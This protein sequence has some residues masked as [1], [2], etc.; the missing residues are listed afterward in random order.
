MAIAHMLIRKAKNFLYDFSCVCKYSMGHTRARE[1][2]DKILIY[3]D[4]RMGDILMDACAVRCL[5][6]YYLQAGKHIYFV[7]SEATRAALALFMSLKEI[8]YISAKMEN[9]D[10]INIDSI[11]KF[12]KQEYFDKI[13][14]FTQWE[15]LWILNLIACANC[16]ESWEVVSKK[17][18]RRMDLLIYFLKCMHR[19]FTNRII[20]DRETHLTDR[21]KLLLTS[22][23]IKDFKT[24][25]VYL[26]KACDFSMPKPYMTISVDS[27]D[28]KRR[29]QAEKFI[30]LIRLLLN[31]RKEDIYLTGVHVD[32]SDLK[33][34]ENAFQCED[35]V[36]MKVG[37]LQL[38]EWV[39]LIRGSSLLIGVDS[40]AIH[41]AASVGTK[42]ICL[43][44]AW[45]G[46]RVIPYQRDI[47]T[48]RTEPPVCVF[49]SDV[50]PKD[51]PCYGCLGIRD[52]GY[53]N[54]QCATECK[55]RRPCLCLQAIEVDDVWNV[56]RN[57]T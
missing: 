10:A 17:K 20:V 5:V 12:L 13:I 44:G 18:N 43:T 1:E 6:D 52:I 25:I 8:T 42:S 56:A 4:G 3:I 37:Q 15:R 51:L 53:G 16:N 48:D 33:K 29:W 27:N 22:L 21:S 2:S 30:Q 7:G 28:S 54:E 49:R 31:H 45:D 41:V 19:D 23:G 39:E 24:S 14:I 32:S 36:K 34:Y 9:A 57:M 11:E 50:D 55:G 38:K 26:P 47:Q 46:R 40:G 35:R